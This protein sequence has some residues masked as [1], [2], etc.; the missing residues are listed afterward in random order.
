MKFRKFVGSIAIRI[1]V[2]SLS[3]IKRKSFEAF[4][5]FVIIA[6]CITLAMSKADKEPTDTEIMI[7]N[8]F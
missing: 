5:I 7:E 8:I 1:N 2:F 3:I 4:T 6:N